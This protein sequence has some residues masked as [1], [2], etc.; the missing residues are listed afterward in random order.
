MT[1]DPTPGPSADVHLTVFLHDLRLDY[2]AH[3]AAA[4]LF[5][6]EWTARH[7]AH[8]A[9]VLPGEPHGYPRLPCERLYRDS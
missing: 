2:R 4:Q 1:A 8:S 9:A 7:G 3:A 5:L 6:R